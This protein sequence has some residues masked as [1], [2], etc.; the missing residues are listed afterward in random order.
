M[1]SS[2]EIQIDDERT[3][4]FLVLDKTGR[5][6]PYPAKTME[7]ALALIKYFT[8]NDPESRCYIIDNTKP[9]K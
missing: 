4:N 8:I 1:I 3:P 6:N 2:Y 5:H 7:Q 9:P